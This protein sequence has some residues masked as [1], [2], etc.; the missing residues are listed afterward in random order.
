MA[1]NY[2]RIQNN[3]TNKVNNNPVVIT[4]NDMSKAVI[5]DVKQY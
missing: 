2:D 5:I 1:Q 3:E 4:Q